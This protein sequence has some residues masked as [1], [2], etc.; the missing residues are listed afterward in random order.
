MDKLAEELPNLNLK[1][2]YLSLYEEK[3]SFEWSRLILA[4]H[5]G[6]RFEI[7]SQGI[8]FKTKNLIPDEFFPENFKFNYILEPLYFHDEQFGFVLLEIDPKLGSIYERLRGSISSAIK[9][10]TLVNE[11]EERTVLLDK[12]YKELK[13]SQQKLLV[14]EKMASLGRITAGIAHEMNTPLAT[15]LAS[16]KEVKMLVDE[17]RKSIYDSRV[18]AKDHEEIITEMTKYLDMATKATEK[19]ASFIRGIK[20]QTTNLNDTM[21]ET[22]KAK[23]VILDSLNLLEF[24]IKRSGVKLEVDLDGAINLYGNQRWLSQIVTNL[25]NN[26]IDACPKKDGVIRVMLNRKEES[27]AVLLV[28][29]T[30]EGIMP[31]NISR[32][33][34]P[35]FTTKPFGEASG[36][37]LSIVRELVG[38]FKGTIDVASKPGMTE[39]KIELPIL[40]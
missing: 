22:F 3:K 26:A 27:K 8:R 13:E 25:V 39:F 36:L 28:E 32:I 37:G 5:K 1:S 31:E 15:V 20:G 33:F 19:G 16:I 14:I 11:M 2:C 40:N 9:G 18:L 24:R 6:K 12:A 38:Q 30:G 17:Y 10:A 29:D 35:L 4:F 21:Y 23:E 34:D 7:E